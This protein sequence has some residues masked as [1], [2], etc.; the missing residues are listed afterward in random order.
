MLPTL[1]R[2]KIADIASRKSS[3]DSIIKK[4]IRNNLSYRYISKVQEF[5]RY[6]QRE[7]I[8]GEKPRINPLV[9]QP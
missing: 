4:F 9:K 6:I 8:G 7:G 2:K 3:M 5:V 1:T